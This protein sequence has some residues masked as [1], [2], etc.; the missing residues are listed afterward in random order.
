[1]SQPLFSFQPGFEGYENK[2]Q[3]YDENMFFNHWVLQCLIFLPS[4][5]LINAMN[6]ACI[7]WNIKRFTEWKGILSD[8][9]CSLLFFNGDVHN[10]SEI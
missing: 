3:H 4:I 8:A 7:L 9:C 2:Y 10:F 5:H 1:M 6:S